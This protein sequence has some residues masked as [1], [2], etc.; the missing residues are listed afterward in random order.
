MTFYLIDGVFG[1][2]SRNLDLKEEG[3][4]TFWEVARREGV[5]EKMKAID[6]HW[7]F[8]IQGELIGPGIQGNIY[9]LSIESGNRAIAQVTRA[10]IIYPDLCEL[11]YIKELYLPPF[12]H[13]DMPLESF[14]DIPI[15]Y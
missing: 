9:K 2:C 4:T 3:G 1:V 7:S 13:Q 12:T 8:A 14:I 10:K 11:L 15:G 5:E 6:E